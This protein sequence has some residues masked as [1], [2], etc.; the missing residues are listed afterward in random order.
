MRT[1]GKSK[2]KAP[3]VI[4]PSAHDAVWFRIL[5]YEWTVVAVILATAFPTKGPSFLCLPKDDNQGEQ[6]ILRVRRGPRKICIITRWP[7]ETPKFGGLLTPPSTRHSQVVQSRFHNSGIVSQISTC[8]LNISTL[9]STQ[10]RSGPLILVRACLT[11]FLSLR[12]SWQWLTSWLQAWWR[13]PLLLQQNAT[14]VLPFQLPLL[15]VQV[16]PMSLRPS[17]TPKQRKG[18]T[19]RELSVSS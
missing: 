6:D 17:S 11:N 1:P 15:Q 10:L 16:R 7:I 4:I 9:L 13:P 2:L 19:K 8:P 3:A 12:S 18:A 14:G 5:T